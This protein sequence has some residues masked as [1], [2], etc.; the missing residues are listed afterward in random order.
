MNRIL[1]TSAFFLLTIITPTASAQSLAIKGAAILDVVS[2]D[3]LR[4]YV[5][6][7]DDGLITQVGSQRS[8]MIP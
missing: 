2:G 4:G 8:V 3:L 7:V 1:K 5:V 6:L